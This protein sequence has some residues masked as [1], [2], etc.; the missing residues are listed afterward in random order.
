MNGLTSI[1]SVVIGAIITI[2]FGL[3]IGSFRYTFLK[4]KDLFLK[5]NGWIDRVNKL[6]E[7]QKTTKEDLKLIFTLLDA[8][9]ETLVRVKAEMEMQMSKLE[10]EIKQ[11]QQKGD[12]DE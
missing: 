7:K 11:I 2:F 1:L 9:K 4:N 8:I 10:K 5:V 6:E 3:I 12:K